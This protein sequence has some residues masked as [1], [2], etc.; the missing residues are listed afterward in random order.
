MAAAA[1]LPLHHQLLLHDTK[2][3]PQNVR[4]MSWARMPGPT[5]ILTSNNSAHTTRS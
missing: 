5:S 4:D 2:C 3:G 1:K